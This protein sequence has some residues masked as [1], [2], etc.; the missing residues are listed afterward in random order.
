[1]MQVF[2]EVIFPSEDNE[3]G[4]GDYYSKGKIHS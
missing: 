3:K 4:K 1:M 2:L